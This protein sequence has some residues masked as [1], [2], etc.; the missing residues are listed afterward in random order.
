[1]T[2]LISHRGKLGPNDD[3]VNTEIMLANKLEILSKRNIMMEI[4]F[5]ITSKIIK[6]GHEYDT[7]FSI[8]SDLLIKYK[9][10]I[11]AH[12]K[13]PL[14]NY[15]YIFLSNLDIESFVHTNEP[16]IFTSKANPFCHS[17]YCKNF[18]YSKDVSLIM[19]EIELSKEDLY[20]HNFLNP[21]LLTEHIDIFEKR[22]RGGV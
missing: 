3:E 11:L 22:N 15:P 8:S 20:N 17:R 13:N 16:V 5:W 18:K 2:R 19:P 10:F 1:M 7:G 21:F 4:D 9:D 14:D 12:I 6:I